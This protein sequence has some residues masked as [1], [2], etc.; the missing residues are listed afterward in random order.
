MGN[1]WLQP[2]PQQQEQQLAE[3]IQTE[4]TALDAELKT[5]LQTAS[6]DATALLS[7]Q[8]RWQEDGIGLVLYNNNRAYDWTTN[9]IPFPTSFDDRHRPEDGAVRLKQSWYLVRTAALSDAQLL[10]AYAL[11]YEDFDF[12]NRYVKVGWSERMGASDRLVPSR[13][14]LQQYA[15]QLDGQPLDMGLRQTEFGAPL[16]TPALAW[17]L[18]SV[19]L[20]LLAL[21]CWYAAHWIAEL[22]SETF[23]HVCFVLLL[24]LLRVL[25]QWWELPH[26][27]Y[28]TELFGP[29]P[30]ATSALIPSLGD[31]L[32]HLLVLMLVLLR[33]RR[34]RWHVEQLALRRFLAV[35][36]PVLLLFPVWEL[37]QTLVSNS[38]FSLDL[39]SPFSLNGYSALGLVASFIGLF[40]YFLLFR[41]LTRMLEQE[42][43]TLTVVAPWLLLGAA[44]LA[45][46]VGFG[47]AEVVFA[48]TS[49]ALLGALMVGQQW[50]ALRGGIYYQ[51]PSMLVFSMIA[52]LMLTAATND[53]ELENRKRLAQKL[54]QK[55]NPITE[56]L[57]ADLAQDITTDRQLRLALASPPLNAN[58][59]LQLIHGKL[60]Y[61]HWNRYINVVDVFNAQGG[62]MMSDR[63]RTGPNFFELQQVYENS[64]PT[65]SENLR[66]VSS[67][68]VQGGYLARIDIEYPRKRE[69]LIAFISLIPEKTDDILGFTDLFVAEEYST[70]KLLEGYSYAVY[71]KGELLDQYGD[72]RYSLDS[73]MYASHRS[74]SGCM[75][76]DGYSHLVTEP[77][78]ERHI[79]VS[80]PKTG[81]LSYLTTFSYLFLFY[82]ACS[83]LVTLASGR[84]WSALAERTSF[85]NRIN[86]AMS[87][88]SF[89]SLV[90]ISVLTVVYVIR[91]YNDRNEEMITEK[92]KSVLIE[93][94]HK[95]SSTADLDSEQR[96]ITTL[97]TKFSKVFFTD[98]NLYRQD[99]HLLATSRPRLFDEGLMAK[100]MD[101]EAYHELHDR[102]RSSFIHEETVADLKYLTAYVPFRNGNGDVVAYMSL[103][104]FA[105]QYGLQQEIFSLLAT[106]T[107]I[108]VFL[109]LISVVLALFIS[110]R[111][112]EPLR[113]IRESLRNLKLDQ[114]NRTI[115]WKSNDEI[116]QLV[117]EYNR[118]LN[119]L[120]RSAE[121]LA[122]SERES[123]WREMAK[124]VAHEIKN[125]LTPMKLS[126]QMLQRSMADGAD[127]LN[128]RVDR[129]SKT[130]IEQIETLSNIATE[131]SSFAKM[132]KSNIEAV[133]L[134]ELMERAAAFHA[135][136]EA[137][138]VLDLAMDEPSI[139]Q[140]DREQMTRVFNN[141]IKNGIQATPDDRTPTITL[142]LIRSDDRWIASVR[143]NGS[144][145]PDELREKIFVPNFTTKSSGM[146]L[147]L[148]MVKN[149][150]ETTNGKIWFESEADK[151]TVF[152]ISF[153]A[154]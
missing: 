146:G 76:L 27:L 44:L 11:I 91:E 22:S 118:T 6:S 145:I 142:G 121:L 152:Y 134:R 17:L 73:E 96:M 82:L 64:T 19:F 149:I 137:E 143:D 133:N 85:R 79:I 110:N 20:V 138:I 109:I 59:V 84:L 126:I 37:F 83:L 38:S 117:D 34:F 31:L 65:I 4:I 98:I 87:S 100:V 128:E 127:D 88:V 103:P 48:L 66:Y 81:I 54:N 46:L 75:E 136:S 135:N 80:R 12:E 53:N 10:V 3:H 90:L 25:M 67:Y 120:V 52:C 55:Q 29:T 41:S 99:G 148:A 69:K 86:L 32:L 122:R 141:L 24:V 77:L 112:T 124:Q 13:P 39:N 144:G 43:R 102:K 123:A 42:K 62:L 5:A 151:G 14:D 129:T 150:I 15:L 154:A 139:V 115:D 21:S 101:P 1:L 106:L 16:P 33:I 7:L 94:Q 56:F 131:F 9:A 71:E 28:S 107:N 97:L 113:I 153:S 8:S 93:L 140:A 47:T 61:D 147:G 116:G 78:Q 68:G 49:S 105:R 26:A 36:L 51:A 63:E 70:A 23:G 60:S 58:Q 104:Y 2:D 108:Y 111:I 132:P 18:W 119:E 74:K 57:F 45:L 92:S 72:Y 35:S 40:N 125:P 89:I 30:H 95:L 114:S 130:L 50:F